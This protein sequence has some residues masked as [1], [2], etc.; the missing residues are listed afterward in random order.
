MCF[1]I[2]QSLKN[3][4]IMRTLI[5]PFSDTDIDVLTFIQGLLNQKKTFRIEPNDPEV[6]ERLVLQA[7]MTEKYV[8][9]GKW[10]NMDD[11]EREDAA[12]VEMMLYAE[13]DPDNETYPEEM[14]AQI[15]ADIQNGKYA[16]RLYN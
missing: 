8:K 1:D 12:L 15:L 2:F 3:D 11:D 14:T 5:L 4:S 13:E 16:T 10:D 9:T 6:L 7:R